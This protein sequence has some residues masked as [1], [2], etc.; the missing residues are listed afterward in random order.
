[1]FVFGTFFCSGDYHNV[2][3]HTCYFKECQGGAEDQHQNDQQIWRREKE[4]LIFS[5]GGH[6]ALVNNDQMSNFT[7]SNH[8]FV[9]HI[10]DPN[11]ITSN[12]MLCTNEHTETV[13]H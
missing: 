4:R 7:N 10:N 9:V 11:S 5:S 12:T 1:M 3:L 6:N 13:H 2:A 8:L